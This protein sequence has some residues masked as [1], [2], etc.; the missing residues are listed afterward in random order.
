MV[1]FEKCVTLMSLITNKIVNKIIYSDGNS[2]TL[3]YKDANALQHIN[4]SDYLANCDKCVVA[5]LE[6][7]AAGLGM[8]ACACLVTC[9]D[10]EKGGL[11]R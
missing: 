10:Q 4:F 6:G 5:F 2:V 9:A 8:I 7:S 3:L 11:G 1:P